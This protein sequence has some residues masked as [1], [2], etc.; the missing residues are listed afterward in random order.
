VKMQEPELT[1][2]TLRAVL[3]PFKNGIP[4][5][6]LQNEY[7][8]L[9]GE[10]IPFR[11]LGH[12]TLEGYLASIPGVVRMERSKMGQVRISYSSEM[13]FVFVKCAWFITLPQPVP[14]ISEKS[15]VG[16]MWSTSA[17]RSGSCG[18][19]KV[20]HIFLPLHADQEVVF[21]QGGRLQGIFPETGVLTGKTVCVTVGLWSL[22]QHF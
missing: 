8:S 14:W 21:A 19:D 11:H 2:K 17:G 16:C 18:I 22:S 6:E 10:W 5:S 4:L 13:A 20:P 15:P 12:G 3:H 9:T 7:R 1:A